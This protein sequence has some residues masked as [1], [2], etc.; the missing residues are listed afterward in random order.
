MAPVPDTPTANAELGCA[1]D[2]SV[3]SQR[4]RARLGRFTL[5]FLHLPLSLSL[6]FSHVSPALASLVELVHAETCVT[7]SDV[8]TS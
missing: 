4:V 6:S 8:P 2:P 3:L 1:A 7:L 5:L